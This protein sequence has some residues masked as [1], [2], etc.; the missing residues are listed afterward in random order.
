MSLR[1]LMTRRM[2]SLGPKY[3]HG[4]YLLRHSNIWKRSFKY[5]EANPNY[6]SLLYFSQA[7]LNFDKTMN[8]LS[9]E[10]SPPCMDIYSVGISPYYTECVVLVCD[11][12]PKRWQEYEAELWKKKGTKSFLW[13][14]RGKLITHRWKE[15]NTVHRD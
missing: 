2:Q 1:R 9:H 7:L 4:R 15:P 10:S 6:C 11:D 13:R 3:N 12:G 8:E 14:R 5:L